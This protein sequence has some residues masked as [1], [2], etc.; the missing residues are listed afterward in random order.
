MSTL[1]DLPSSGKPTIEITVIDAA[2]RERAG[3]VVPF[4]LVVRNDTGLRQRKCTYAPWEA[5]GARGCCRVVSRDCSQHDGVWAQQGL[6]KNSAAFRVHRIS[7][8]H[9][10]FGRTALG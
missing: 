1:F 4:V 2:G 5:L 6:R 3:T 10:G 9:R 8:S 7:F